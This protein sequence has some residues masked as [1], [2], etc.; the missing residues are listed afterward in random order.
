[1]HKKIEIASNIAIIIVALLFSAFLVSRYLL[2]DSAP[3]PTALAKNGGVKPGIKLQFSGIDWSKSEKTLVLALSTSCRYCTESVPLYQK[4]AQQKA[5][6]SNVRLLAVMPQSF[7]EAQRYLNEHGVSVDEI[8]QV[9]LDEINV[10]GTPTLIMVDQTGTVIHSWVG[11]LPPE[12]ET[13]VKQRF[14]G[15]RFDS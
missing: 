12:K 9:G 10:K 11:K 1:M 3:K 7:D 6:R 15:D 4:L 14:L 2:P 13:E 5:G 8:R